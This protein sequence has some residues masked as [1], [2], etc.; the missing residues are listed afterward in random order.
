LVTPRHEPDYP[1]ESE[2]NTFVDEPNPRIS[3]H[4]KNMEPVGEPLKSVAKA[5]KVKLQISSGPAPPVLNFEPLPYGRRRKRKRS[6]EENGPKRVKLVISAKRLHPATKSNNILLEPLTEIQDRAETP[7]DEKPLI[8][9]LKFRRRNRKS[10]RN[11]GISDEDV[12]L[13]MIPNV[14]FL[15][16]FEDAFDD[17]D[18]G[19]TTIKDLAE[20]GVT[21]MEP[22]DYEDFYLGAYD[23][24][25][26]NTEMK[27]ETFED[28]ENND[29]ELNFP[30]RIK[31]EPLDED[32][33]E[34]NVSKSDVGKKSNKLGF[35]ERKSTKKPS[36]NE[37]DTKTG[38]D[39]DYKVD[40]IKEESD[41]PESEPEADYEEQPNLEDSYEEP[42]EKQPDNEIKPFKR[43]LI[44]KR[45]KYN[46]P[47]NDSG[48]GGTTFVDGKTYECQYC[49][50]SS[51]KTEWISHLKKDH[52]DKDLVFCP[53]KKC[54]MPFENEA[55]MREHEENSHI[56]NICTF[57]GCGK[58]FKFKSV[59]REHRKTHYPADCDWMADPDPDMTI[60]RFFVCTYCGKR[61]RTR[62]GWR[63]HEAYV[64]T[65][66]LDF[67]CDEAGCN[68]AFFAENELVVHKRKHSG[69]LPFTCSYCGNRYISAHS[70]AQ[71]EKAAHLQTEDVE[72]EVCNKKVR[73]RNLPA[74]VKTHSEFKGLPCK[75]CSK[76]FPTIGSL[77]RHEKIHTDTK[78][79]KCR[80]CG[81]G[82]VQ[83]ANMQSHE[84]IHTG[85][86]PYKC[87]Y[88]NEGFVQSTRRRQH[89]ATC[90]MKRQ[91][92]PGHQQ[93]QS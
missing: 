40:A 76:E 92:I 55:E 5:P 14:S 32:A 16:A 83:K 34:S 29:G 21:K 49:D 67:L 10:R 31:D 1:D 18:D 71:H 54:Q 72:C 80:F 88:C 93:S 6:N 45:R 12:P 24:D 3:S 57:E 79:H 7:E 63:A 68:K 19:F 51:K 69:E 2:S 44:K 53:L 50:F 81:K 22:L 37:E 36:K 77:K 23:D 61:Y 59:L 27:N 15:D 41:R 91:L 89:E 47:S 13:S 85:E 52:E 82:F 87:Q 42:P 26:F 66:Q 48:G 75:F 9:T 70:L 11:E 33:T 64:H 86:R 84:R 60:D 65:K 17:N 28:G 35:N 78:E 56:K 58:E 46:K 73:K 20:R 74:H 30:G 25:S 8:E 4:D 38:D 39:I 62:T 90:K 43:R